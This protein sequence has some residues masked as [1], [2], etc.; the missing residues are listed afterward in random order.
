MEV[1]SEVLA[2]VLIAY[3]VH[4]FLDYIF[5]EKLGLNTRDKLLISFILSVIVIKFIL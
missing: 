4:R 3:L 2:V 5:D 1:K